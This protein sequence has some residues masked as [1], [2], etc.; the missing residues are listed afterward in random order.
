MRTV[1]AMSVARYANSAVTG[2]N[3]QQMCCDRSLHS[4]LSESIKNDVIKKLTPAQEAAIMKLRSLVMYPAC[5]SNLNVVPLT[6]STRKV[7][8]ARIHRNSLGLAVE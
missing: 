5:D 6:S 1:L 3:L 7:V 4:F 2:M 8:G